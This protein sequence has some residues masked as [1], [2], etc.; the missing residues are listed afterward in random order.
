MALRW[1]DGWVGEHDGGWQGR[2]AHFPA[3]IW[4]RVL[5]PWN[6][7][8]TQT[9]PSLSCTGHGVFITATEKKHLNCSVSTKVALKL[10]VQEEKPEWAA[11]TAKT[12]GGEAFIQ[13]LF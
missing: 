1:G 6:R 2:L 11:Q 3:L 9:L 5:F 8:S 12:P 4:L 7:T 13:A 10:E